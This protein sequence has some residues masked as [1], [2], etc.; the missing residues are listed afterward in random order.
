MKRRPNA[1][2]SGENKHP[3]AARAASYAS[4]KSA[5]RVA[6]IDIGVRSQSSVGSNMSD[7]GAV[8]SVEEHGD[9]FNYAILI[10][11]YTLQGIPMGI[12][13]EMGG[14]TTCAGISKK[15]RRT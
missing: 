2:M 5:S 4:Q 9:G 3:P 7:A 10:A 12:P 8:E 13:F 14:S 11:L 15:E 6:M 1:I